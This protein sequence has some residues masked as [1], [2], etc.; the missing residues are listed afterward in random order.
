MIYVRVKDPS[1]GHQFDRPADDPMI[2]DG[3][4]IPLNSKRWPPAEQARPPL[5]HVSPASA[6]PQDSGEVP[7]S[8]EITPEENVR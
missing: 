5:F 1:S 4:L 8:P 6:A 3:T 2:A 7:D